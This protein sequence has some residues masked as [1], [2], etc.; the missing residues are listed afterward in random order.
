MTLSKVVSK[1]IWLRR[2]LEDLDFVQKNPTT[3]FGDNQ[4][5]FSLA[6]KIS[7]YIDI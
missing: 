6:T 1:A 4:S 5:Y 7:T 3:L 2:L